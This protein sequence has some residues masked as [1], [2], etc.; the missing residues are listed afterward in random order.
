MQR[1]PQAQYIL[2]LKRNKDHIRSLSYWKPAFKQQKD[3]EKPVL[4]RNGVTLSNWK[5]NH[6]F[7]FL[8]CC[9][10]TSYS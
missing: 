7:S 2:S 1:E 4:F 10:A 8:V 6:F 3:F 5:E 9:F